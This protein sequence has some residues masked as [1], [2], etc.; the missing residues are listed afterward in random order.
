MV[1]VQNFHEK[2]EQNLIQLAEEIQAERA[3]PESKKLPEEEIMKR[4]VKSFARTVVPS[5]SSRSDTTSADEDV[6]LPTYLENNGVSPA[7]KL[8][9]EELVDIVFHKGLESALKAASKHTP[10]VEDA[11]HD[12]L[13]DKLLPILKEKGLWK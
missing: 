12:A 8:E 9:I 5:A 11:F 7:A 2:L 4:S 3:R 6:G 13:V 10:F 1:R